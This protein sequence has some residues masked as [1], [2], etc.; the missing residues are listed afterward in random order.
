MRGRSKLSRRSALKRRRDR[1]R[2]RQH[3]ARDDAGAVPVREPV[4]E[5]QHDAGEEPGLGHPKPS[6]TGPIFSR[7]VTHTGKLRQVNLNMAYRSLCQLVALHVK[8]LDLDAAPLGSFQHVTPPVAR[9]RT[10]R[11]LALDEYFGRAPR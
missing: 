10:Y 11:G 5:E 4:G 8:T 6:D 2:Q 9:V 3:E 7:R 1:E